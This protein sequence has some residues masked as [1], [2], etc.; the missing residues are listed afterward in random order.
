VSALRELAVNELEEL[1]VCLFLPGK[2]LREQAG[3]LLEGGITRERR[4]LS[5]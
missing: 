1:L 3:G 2:I 4:R 5:L